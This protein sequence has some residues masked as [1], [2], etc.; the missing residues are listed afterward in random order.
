MTSE[1]HT[2]RAEDRLT[3][4][5]RALCH[6]LRDAARIVG[7]AGVPAEFRASAFAA[8]VPTVTARATIRARGLRRRA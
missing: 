3:P 2:R 7:A 8:V 4:E 1:D 5:D 6:A